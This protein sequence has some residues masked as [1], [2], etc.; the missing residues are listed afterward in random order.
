MR[1]F[2]DVLLVCPPWYPVIEYVRSFKAVPGEILTGHFFMK[3][4]VKN[5]NTL[6]REMFNGPSL[7]VF[8]M[9]LDNALNN[10][11]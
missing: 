9:H 5:Y 8:N 1:S 6:P 3:K 2:A 11:F 4:A 10:V 7:A